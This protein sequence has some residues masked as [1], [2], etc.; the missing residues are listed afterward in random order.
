MAAA[1]GP[2]GGWRGRSLLLLL[3]LL[4]AAA[5]RASAYVSITPE[6]NL[7]LYGPTS[8][9]SWETTTDHSDLYV[10]GNVVLGRLESDLDSGRIMLSGE[11][12]SLLS[13][14]GDI[15]VVPSDKFVLE[16]ARGDSVAVIQAPICSEAEFDGGIRPTEFD[17]PALSGPEAGGLRCANNSGSADLV[18]QSS[19]TRWDKYTLTTTIAGDFELV[20]GT[21]Q[22]TKFKVHHEGN[23][24]S[25]G[26]T[27]E[28]GFW[29]GDTDKDLLVTGNIVGG[30]S[31]GN[32]LMK[33]NVS[34]SDSTASTISS[35]NSLSAVANMDLALIS[36]SAGVLVAS[37]D[38]TTVSSAA[39]ILLTA[40]QHIG[41]DGTGFALR[42]TQ[43]GRITALTELAFDAPTMGVAADV[44]SIAV[45]NSTSFS[46][47]T[48]AVDV[49][50]VADISAG[51]MSVVSNSTIE[52]I[53]LDFI[54]TVTGS[55]NVMTEE[56]ILSAVGDAQLQAGNVMVASQT[57]ATV[58]VIN[59]TTINGGSLTGN[60]AQEIEVKSHNASLQTRQSITANSVEATI[61]MANSFDV[62]AGATI[63]STTNNESHHAFQQMTATA[64]E[65]V[66]VAAQ[67]ATLDF[68]ATVDLSARDLRVRNSGD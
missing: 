41:L 39:N 4:A 61:S 24:V 21:G 31:R 55:L 66:T 18:L 5:G 53:S 14:Y 36:A 44:V 57:D 13:T 8:V 54:S 17:H 33:G 2:A 50:G 60:F 7:T 10:T 35:N 19:G 59:S 67:D 3:A 56:S 30:R 68:G 37:A 9:G 51:E 11:N 58:T 22:P 32:L 65:R 29:E 1:T 42:V 45:H 15:N 62:F 20:H 12:A 25:L 26:E 63:D 43:G 40:S 27:T 28:I 52:I 48:A 49:M 23:K 6:G 38:T 16:S 64:G 34:L 46:S 47:Y